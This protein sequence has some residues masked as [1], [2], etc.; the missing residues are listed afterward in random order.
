MLTALISHFMMPLIVHPLTGGLT[1]ADAA[2]AAE[3]DP[4]SAPASPRSSA[5]EP[6]ERPPASWSL[7]FAASFSSAPSASSATP[8]A[9]A[10]GCSYSSNYDADVR[11]P[12]EA[13]DPLPR[14]LA[15]LVLSHCLTVLSYPPLLSAMTTLLLHPRLDLVSVKMPKLDLLSA[16]LDLA[17]SSLEGLARGGTDKTTGKFASGVVMPIADSGPER[18]ALRAA[19]VSMASDTDERFVFLSC[20]AL[21]AAIRCTATTAGASGGGGGGGGGGFSDRGEPSA[22]PGHTELLKQSYLLPLRH[23][24]SE[25]LLAQLLKKQSSSGAFSSAAAGGVAAADGKSS[26]A[27]RPGQLTPVGGSRG[28]EAEADEVGYSVPLVGRLLAFLL[29]AAGMDATV[30]S[31]PPLP[32]AALAAAPPAAAPAAEASRAGSAAVVRLVTVQTAVEL[33]VDL[34]HDSSSST[35]LIRDHAIVLEAAHS[36]AAKGLRASLN[37]RFAASLGNLVEYES[38]Q[39]PLPL[40]PSFRLSTL[41][42]D[43]SL[44][45]SAEDVSSLH[46]VPL[47]RRKPRD[48]LE[49]TRALIQVFLLTRHARN[50]LLRYPDDV[51]ALAKPTASLHAGTEL[52]LPT[53]AQLL[54]CTLHVQSRQPES[55]RL[56]L[57]PADAPPPAPP[58]AASPPHAEAAKATDVTDDPDGK[59]AASDEASGGAATTPQPSGIAAARHLLVLVRPPPPPLP[60]PSLSSSEESGGGG[61]SG[62]SVGGGTAG[63]PPTASAPSSSVQI[64][65]SVPLSALSITVAPGGTMLLC[66]V[67]RHHAPAGL[68]P[69]APLQLEFEEAWRCL[70]AKSQLEAA[71]AA[72]RAEMMRQLVSMLRGS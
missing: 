14:L 30:Y 69:E 35:P 49:A 28:Y 11:A 27:F 62:S 12:A 10:S 40:S 22:P 58:P 70:A 1:A 63:L 54:P 55:C 6:S 60:L 9:S 47:A 32:G 65:L 5:A 18:N 64:L 67:P 33:L 43:C 41:I 48:E 34:V 36:A 21:I 3:S 15:L 25:S 2:L 50:I 38:R 26:A 8:A 7:A 61:G 52:S 42:G 71:C 29:R 20:C 39:L 44:L 59:A 23:R 4:S 56:L 31:S 37:G 53:S 13:V 51:R 46:S 45:L 57:Y 66:R 19:V 24:R 68:N 16:K 17:R 72:A